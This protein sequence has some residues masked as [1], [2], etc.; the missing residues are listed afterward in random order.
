VT[1]GDVV[2]YYEYL[3]GEWKL[4]TG[5]SCECGGNPRSFF[6]GRRPTHGTKPNLEEGIISF[7]CV[8]FI[9]LDYRLLRSQ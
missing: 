1:T 5:A 9:T 3:D 6:H 7:A 4:S 8:Q 2:V